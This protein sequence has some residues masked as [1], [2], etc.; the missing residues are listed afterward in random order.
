[1]SPGEPEPDYFLDPLE[2]VIVPVRRRNEW[3]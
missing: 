1:M 2:W 3:P